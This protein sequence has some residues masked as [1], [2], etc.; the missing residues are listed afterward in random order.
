MGRAT[1]L[2]GRVAI[3]AGGSGGI[4]AVTV[5]LLLARGMRVAIAAQNDSLLE[6]IAA[7]TVSYGERVLVVPT[8]ITR[9]ADVD[10]LVAH[11]MNAFGRID[12][13]A[14]VAGVGSRPSFADSTNEE[15]ERVVLV[16]LLGAALLMHA[17]IPVMKAHGGGAIVNVGSVAGEAGVMGMYSATKFGLRGLCDT[18]RR[19]MRSHNI[20]VSLIEPAF[21][22]TRMNAAMKGLPPPEIVADA[23][24]AAV[25]R[26]RR[27]RIVPAVYRV[28]VLFTKLFPGLTDLIFGDARI[29]RQLN[30]NAEVE[31]GGGS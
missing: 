21:V 28:P 10:D 15:L 2:D 22:A 29:Q 14:N 31:M 7:E 4:G 11:T 5:K 13:L 16:N 6:A 8:D 20:S 3:V 12:V 27:V 1:S 25:V 18:V 9:R 30:R 17:V 26:P 24:V 23:I 19:E